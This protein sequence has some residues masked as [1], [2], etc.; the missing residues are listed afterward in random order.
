[1][2]EKLDLQTDD[3]LL[4]AGQLEIEEDK[5]AKVRN[6]VSRVSIKEGWP[7][8]SYLKKFNKAIIGLGDFKDS[9]QHLIR[10][11]FD[12]AFLF[13]P[14]KR[15]Y[16][17]AARPGSKFFSKN[18]IIF[19]VFYSIEELLKK[20]K[21]AGLLIKKKDYLSFRDKVAQDLFLNPHD[22]L[23][24]AIK[25]ILVDNYQ[26]T[27]KGDLEEE[28]AEEIIEKS[29]LDDL[30]DRSLDELGKKQTLRLIQTMYG[31]QFYQKKQKS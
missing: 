8:L 10:S 2:F 12:Q 1:M 24:K 13:M 15:A 5:L 30:L 19:K 4:L 28:E 3:H 27:F 9:I 6:K 29:G 17:L 7:D 25:R 18:S 31:I 11:G 16:E 14:I 26:E 20:D 23:K 22:N 21:E